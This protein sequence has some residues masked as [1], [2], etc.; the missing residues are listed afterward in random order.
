[1]DVIASKKLI[2][3]VDDCVSESVEG[4]LMFN[5]QLK[6]LGNLNVVIRAD[7]NELKDRYVSILTGGKI[8]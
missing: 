4:L 2:N 7:I 3:S 8:L 5:P 6:R 1:M